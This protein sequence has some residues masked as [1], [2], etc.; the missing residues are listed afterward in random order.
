MHSYSNLKF[1]KYINMIAELQ[2]STKNHLSSIHC[3]KQDLKSLHIYVQGD[4][5][6]H[7]LIIIIIIITITII[8]I[9]MHCH[10]Y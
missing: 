9:V 2:K 3:Q 1:K 10:H 8:N 7:C 4:L 6:I 5:I